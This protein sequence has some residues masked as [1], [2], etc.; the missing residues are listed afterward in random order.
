LG[1]LGDVLGE[2]D[3]LFQRLAR[4]DQIMRKAEPLAGRRI[5]RAAGRIIST[6][7]PEPMMRATATLAPPPPRLR[8]QPAEP[9]LTRAEPPPAA[10]LPWIAPRKSACL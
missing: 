10:L 8:L 7:R 4:L 5:Q 2:L 6:M 3:G 9:A 1:V